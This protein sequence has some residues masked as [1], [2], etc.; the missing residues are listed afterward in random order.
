MIEANKF[1]EYSADE[2]TAIAMRMREALKD[3]WQLLDAIGPHAS[4]AAKLEIL[5]GAKFSS[6]V[7]SVRAALVLSR[8]LES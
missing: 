3:A 7:F 1:G 4:D 8:R 6:A 5:S 2:R